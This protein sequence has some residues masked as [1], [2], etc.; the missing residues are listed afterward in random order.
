MRDRLITWLLPLLAAGIGVWVWTLLPDLQQAGVP[1]DLR[2]TGYG[3]TEALA[4]VAALTPEAMATYLGPWRI[5]DTLFPLLMMPALLLP[6]WGRGQMW[7]LPALAYGLADLGEN[8]AVAR[9]LTAGAEM[10]ASQ[11]MLA[12]TLTQGKFLAL[13]LAVGL[14]AWAL[15]QGWRTR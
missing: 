1:F 4:Y 14:A 10:T 8:N 11:V 15:W 5:A 13:G 7:F 3:L 12:S 9:L 2:L 6:L